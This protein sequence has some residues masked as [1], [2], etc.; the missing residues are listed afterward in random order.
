MHTCGGCHGTCR[1]PIFLRGSTR[2]VSFVEIDLIGRA[3]AASVTTP[4]LWVECFGLAIDLSPLLQNDLAEATTGLTFKLSE[5]PL[6]QLMQQ[7]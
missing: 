7:Q 2:L 4:V 6:L 3:P 5:C 1:A